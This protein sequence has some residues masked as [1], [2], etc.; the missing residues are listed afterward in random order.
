MKSITRRTWAMVLAVS[1]PCV[2][3]TQTFAEGSPT[4]KDEV[5]YVNLNHDGS[6]DE[7]Y[8]VNVFELAQPGKITDYGDRKSDV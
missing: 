2:I 7:I 5:V 1:M 8:V 3:G 6:V 4:S